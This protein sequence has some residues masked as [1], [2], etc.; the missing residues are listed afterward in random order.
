M[1][2]I[3]MLEW[4][5]RRAIKEANLDRNPLH[6]KALL[7]HIPIKMAV[8]V[9]D[10][11]YEEVRRDPRLQAI[12]HEIFQEEVVNYCRR[13]VVPFLNELNA[14]WDRIST[15]SQFDVSWK[16]MTRKLE[17]SLTDIRNEAEAKMQKKL[18][19]DAQLRQKYKHYRWKVAKQTA[20]TTLAVGTAVAGTAGSVA[21][22]GATLGLAVVGLYRSVMSAVKL[23]RDSAIEA[24]TCQKNV[25]YGLAHV[26]KSYGLMEHKGD[27]ESERFQNL[28]QADMV[29]YSPSSAKKAGNTAKEIASN[30]VINSVLKWS[31]LVKKTLKSVKDIKVETDLW[32]NKLANLTFQSRDL[33]IKLNE[34][35]EK[36]DD[37]THKLAENDALRMS[38]P[39]FY[40]MVKQAAR[41]L[42]REDKAYDRTL[43][44]A[45]KDVKKLLEKGFYIPSMA[46]WITIDELHRRAETGLKRV[47]GLKPIL[48]ALETKG[49]GKGTMIASDALD[50]ALGVALALAGDTYAPVTAGADGEKFNDALSFLGSNWFDCFSVPQ[51]VVSTTNSLYSFAVDTCGAT[52]V[53]SEAAKVLLEA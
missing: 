44:K 25:I 3:V 46:K 16:E 37:L 30:F 4:T 24:E 36:M 15:L 29:G 40:A 47:E 38:D 41:E 23:I 43:E 2:K 22:G 26:A 51:D 28:S 35:L 20:L 13:R 50:I 52:A 11:E 53:R 48:D 21:A 42:E 5:M 27:G 8:E 9:P 12:L 39:G 34:L 31:G 10:E 17:H 33:S 32:E 7:P 18:T 14:N 49:L 19:E 45:E 6:G 1:K